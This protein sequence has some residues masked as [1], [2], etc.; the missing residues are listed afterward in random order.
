MRLRA[1]CTLYS[2]MP[3]WFNVTFRKNNKSKRTCKKRRKPARNRQVGRARTRKATPEECLISK[4]FPEDT[5]FSSEDS[6]YRFAG[7][8]VPCNWFTGLFRK[9][10]CCLQNAGISTKLKVRADQYITWTEKP[11]HS[12]DLILQKG[13]YRAPKAKKGHYIVLHVS[14]DNAASMPMVKE[15]LALISAQGVFYTDGRYA[16]DSKDQLDLGWR[17]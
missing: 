14:R 6:G 3:S 8:A 9:I 7:N 4:S 17:H 16:M 10:T 15:E 11:I 1:M 2:T 13:R 5:P 12:H